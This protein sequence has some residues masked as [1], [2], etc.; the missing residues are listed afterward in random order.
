MGERDLMGAAIKGLGRGDLQPLAEFLNSPLPFDG[1]EG[2]S[3]L[4][5]KLIEC[6]EGRALWN[7]EMKKKRYSR[8][9]D[10]SEELAADFRDL[11]IHPCVA[12]V[13]ALIAAGE[14]PERAVFAA[15][16][17]FSLSRTAVY[18]A[19][20]GGYGKRAVQQSS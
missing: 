7:L 15:T 8:F 1:D 16:K 3:Y 4:R 14:T 19:K 5:H 6:I 11:G 13:E 2:D 17:E 18:A 9:A 12:F 20:P 10:E